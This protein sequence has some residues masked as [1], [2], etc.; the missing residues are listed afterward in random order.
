MGFKNIVFR[1]IIVAYGIVLRNPLY[2]FAALLPYDEAL[3]INGCAIADLNG[4]EMPEMY[5]TASS[6]WEYR[7]YYYMNGEVLSVDDIEPWTW[8]NEL[9]YTRDGRLVMR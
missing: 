7:A 5:L 4:D 9:C 2:D 6:G 3:C 8:S 1:M